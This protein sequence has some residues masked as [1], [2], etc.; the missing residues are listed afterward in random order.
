MGLVKGVGEG[1]GI[2]VTCLTCLAESGF[3]KS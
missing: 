1:R 3:E 2:C